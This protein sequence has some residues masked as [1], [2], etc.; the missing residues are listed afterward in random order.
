MCLAFWTDVDHTLTSVTDPTALQICEIV[1][2]RD[3][4]VMEWRNGNCT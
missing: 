1:F 4:N 3:R 2:L